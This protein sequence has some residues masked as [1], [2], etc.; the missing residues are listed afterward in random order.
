LQALC[1][2]VR[3][4]LSWRQRLA[5]K[6]ACRPASP[7]RSRVRRPDIG[8]NLESSTGQGNCRSAKAHG[9]VTTPWNRLTVARHC[10]LPCIRANPHFTL[11]SWGFQNH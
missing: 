5:V 4:I 10:T 11:S 6:H 9:C 2:R 8:F 1:L 7:W 3:T